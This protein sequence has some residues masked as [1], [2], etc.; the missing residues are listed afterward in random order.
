MRV[1]CI[2]NFIDSPRK[3]ILNAEMMEYLIIDT[4]FLVF[5]VRF[6]RNTSYFY[7]FNG[8]HLFEVPFDFFKII[9]DKVSEDWKVKVWENGDVTLW[10]DLFYQDCFL[11]NFAER[12]LVER[13]LFDNLIVK[14]C[15]YT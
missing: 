14:M 7:L 11:E 8:N 13:N 2:K 5:G 12:E 4:T 1:K 15:N 6:S 3:D 10:P 9:D